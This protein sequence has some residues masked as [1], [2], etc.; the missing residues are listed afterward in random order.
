[1]EISQLAFAGHI[2]PLLIITLFVL[3]PAMTIMC[4]G[5]GAPGGLFTPSLA[6]GALLGGALGYAW[7]VVVPDAPLGAYAVVGATAMLAATTQGQFPP[8]C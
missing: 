7:S 5:S 4:L 8:S 2:G 3:K 1:M 6:V